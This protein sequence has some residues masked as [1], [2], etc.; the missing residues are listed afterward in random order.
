[1]ARPPS[2]T[3]QIALR[4]PT[5]WQTEADELA[6]LLSRPGVVASRSDAY[7]AAMARGFEVLRAELKLDAKMRKQAADFD[8]EA[9]AA[10]GA[11]L[12]K[13]RKPF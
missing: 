11:E 1:M 12:D 13:A 10:L 9:R 8:A 6:E 4:V 5:S 2:D 7:R 3:V